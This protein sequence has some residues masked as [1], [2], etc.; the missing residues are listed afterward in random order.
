MKTVR[1]SV[2]DYPR[3]YDVLFGSDWKA[4]YDFLTACF[5]RHA[6]RPVK[7]LFEPG[8]GTGRLLVKFAQ[9][10][11]AVAGNDLNPKAVAYCNARLKRY[12]FAATADVGD[13]ADFRLRRKVDAAFNTINTFRH[14]DSQEKAENHLRCMARAVSPG[15]LYLLG[16]HLTPTRGRACDKEFWAA[17]RGSLEIKSAMWSIR[18][19]RRHRREQVGFR[20]DIRTPRQRLRLEDRFAFRTYTA[21]EMADLLDQ[22]P[23]FKVVATYDFNYDTNSPIRVGPSTEDVVYTLRKRE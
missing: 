23:E 12:G 6:L 16:L 19:D 10:G 3:Y 7:R 4:E 17:R 18:I 11:Y 1:G 15:G 20:L 13:M 2:Y 8:C 21:H 5:R 22:I 14:L 9:A